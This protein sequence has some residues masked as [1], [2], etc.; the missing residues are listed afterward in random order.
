MERID[1]GKLSYFSSE[2]LERRAAQWPGI[3]LRHGFSTRR[4]GV[5]TAEHL[6]EM[7]FG[8]Q[9]GEPDEITRE[10]YTVFAHA[11]EIEP[12]HVVCTNQT[13]TDIVFRVTEQHRGMG[14]RRPPDYDG[15]GVPEQNEADALVTERTD[16]ALTVRVADCVP[17]LLWDPE[18]CVIG[19]A[20]A[21]WKGTHGQIAARTVHI[22]EQY[23]AEAH[24]VYAAIGPAVG[25]CCYEVDDDFYE[26]FQ[27]AFGPEITGSCFCR[28]GGTGNAPV[29][30]H[31]DLKRLNRILLEE[32]GVP[33]AHI[34]VSDDCT[35]CHPELF[36]SHRA[37]GGRRGTMAA[38]ISM[39]TVNE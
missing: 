35:C 24:S 31:A 34:D 21:G 36:H 3:R 7:N 17:I 30:W 26:R 12:S 14:W 2:L 22:M 32:A 27:S 1:W 13:H 39:E 11:L 33:A 29:R 9:R 6:Q 16:V 8:F 28:R 20:H 15:S 10:N 4:G 18:H 23:G 5:S 19:A 37:T 38:M 25:P